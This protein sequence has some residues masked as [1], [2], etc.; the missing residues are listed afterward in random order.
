[1]R[2]IVLARLKQPLCGGKVEKDPGNRHRSLTDG[3]GEKGH[4]ERKEGGTG[5]L[6]KRNTALVSMS[7]LPLL[8]QEGDI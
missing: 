7:A 1:M 3:D 4:S 2:N 5:G 8:L 6:R